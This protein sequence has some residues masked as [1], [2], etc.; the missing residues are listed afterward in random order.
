M[1]SLEQATSSV[2]ESIT[3]LTLK[4]LDPGGGRVQLPDFEML[5]SDG[6]RVG[7]LEVTS[8]TREDRARFRAQVGIQNWE[9]EELAFSWIVVTRRSQANPRD[10]ARSLG[11]ELHALEVAGRTGE[12]I[13]KG[14]VSEGDDAL[15]RS[16]T[17]LGILRVCAYFR[18]TPGTKG[19][20]SVQAEGPGGFF[21]IS[22]LTAEVQKPLDNPGNQT[23]LRVASGGQ[24]ELFVW[25]DVGDGSA[26]LAT[27][28]TP[29]FD[30]R[31]PSLPVPR[32][33]AAT[34]VWAGT[35]TGNPVR[36]AVALARVSNGTWE[37]VPP[38]TFPG[39]A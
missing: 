35:T 32:L 7:I 39:V 34:A 33:G 28:K 22:D 8:T 37:I 1:D 15:P 24:A 18:N 13:P 6:V 16:L 25:L 17:T 11:N 23:K 27:L 38:P 2:V 31:L 29:P 20:V 3:G 30:Q 21:D 5:A 10:L 4:P 12:W 26:A 9:F 36:P 19:W 14:P